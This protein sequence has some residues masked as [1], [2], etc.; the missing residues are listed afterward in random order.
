MEFPN[1]PEG[2]KLWHPAYDCVI[3]GGHRLGAAPTC[4][5]GSHFPQ[6]LRQP[7]PLGL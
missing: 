3:M 6:G 4:I 7:T 2:S 5:S 1:P